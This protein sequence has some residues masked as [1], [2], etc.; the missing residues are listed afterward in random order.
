VQ[1]VAE[2]DTTLELDDTTDELIAMELDDG[3]ELDNATLELDGITDEL[4]AI[5]LDDGV[6]LDNTTLELDGTNDELIEMELNDGLELD[7]ATME[8]DC[9]TDELNTI[10]LDSWLELLLA[11]ELD[12]IITLLHSTDVELDE[13][14]A[15]ELETEEVTLL[16][17]AQSTSNELGF[18]RSIVEHATRTDIIP[19]QMRPN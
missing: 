11:N 4:F 15:D 17:P 9:I 2:L 14:G 10:G 8:L 19:E 5:E 18:E 12:E 13:I 16:V 6:E 1:T 7:N 3:V